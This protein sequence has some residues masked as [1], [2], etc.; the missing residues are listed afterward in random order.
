MV[1]M[2]EAQVNQQMKV[3]QETLNTAKTNYVGQIAKVVETSNQAKK[4]IEAKV[5]LK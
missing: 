3:F 4:Q 2:L 5:P 1:G